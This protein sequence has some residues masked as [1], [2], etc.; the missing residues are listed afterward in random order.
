MNDLHLSFAGLYVRQ[1]RPTKTVKLKFKVP[2]NGIKVESH[3]HF[4]TRWA[5][6]AHKLHSL[7]KKVELTAVRESPAGEW[8]HLAA[9]E[10]RTFSMM[11]SLYSCICS[12]VTICIETLLRKHCPYMQ[13]LYEKGTPVLCILTLLFTS[14]VLSYLNSFC[15]QH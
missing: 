12:Q 14:L 2:T 7:V 11:F 10:I 13:M 6:N 4:E 9:E 15:S 8:P 3:V 1:L 5:T